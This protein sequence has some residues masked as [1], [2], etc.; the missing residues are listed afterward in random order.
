MI[1]RLSDRKCQVVHRFPHMVTPLILASGSEIRRHLLE[2]AGVSVE[3]VVPRID[4]DS[5][6]R[7]LLAE[8]AGSRDV[9]DALAELKSR[10]VAE[11]RPEAFVIGCDQVLDLSGDILSKPSTP[12][13][14]RAQL[15][16]MNGRRHVLFS[17]VVVH[18]EARPVWRHVGE[19]RLTMRSCSDAYLDDYVARNWDTIRHSV[20]SYKIE[21]EG[22]RLFSRIEGDHFTILG[23]PVLEL[24]SY[25][26]LRGRVP[27]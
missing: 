2:N 20:G 25:L 6:K 27:G 1:Q 9:A 15:D 16:R 12:E 17:A 7:S 8:G 11:R 5:V 23:L 18:E 26:T 10:R 19:A 22:L 24:L 14:A 4:E 21:E 13:E 3:T